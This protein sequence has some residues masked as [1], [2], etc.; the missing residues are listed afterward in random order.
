MAAVMQSDAVAWNSKFDTCATV[1]TTSTTSHWS[2]ILKR[3]A[4]EHFYMLNYKH[5]L[6]TNLKIIL[7]YLNLIIDLRFGDEFWSGVPGVGK[8]NIFFGSSLKA[9][10]LYSIFYFFPIG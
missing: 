5:T 7:K 3:F 8:G 2:Q 1:Q 4:L 9:K 10:S 6:K